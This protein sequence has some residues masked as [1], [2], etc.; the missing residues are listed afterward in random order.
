MSGN[1]SKSIK[2]SNNTYIDGTGISVDR[3]ILADIIYPVGSIY[4]SM[5][6]ANPATLFGGTWTQISDRFLYCVTGTTK[7]LGGEN[8]HTLNVNEIPSHSHTVWGRTGSE[9]WAL[10]D[11]WFRAAGDG[12]SNQG[13]TANTSNAGGSQ[14]HNN[15]PQYIT[16]HAWYRES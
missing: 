16:V 5:N 8:T 14:P 13:R 10:G 12:S 4:L 9:Q 1:M 11:I 7:Q 6:D 3:K 2:F 15:M